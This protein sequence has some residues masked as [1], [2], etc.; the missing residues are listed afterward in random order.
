MKKTLVALVVAAVAGSANAG[1]ELYN[2]GGVTVNMKG[3]IEVQYVQAIG[4]DEQLTQKI[5]DAD[6]GFDT[7]YAID[8]TTQVGFYYEFSGADNDKKGQADLASTGD[9]YV[10]FYNDQIGT[11]KI[12]KLATQLDD[13]GIG[14]DH[15]FGITKFFDDAGFGGHEAVRYDLDKGQFYF[16]LGLIQNKL[17]ANSKLGEADGTHFDAKVG[18]RADAFDVRAFAGQSKTDATAPAVDNKFTLLALEGTYS[19]IENVNLQAAVYSVK[20]DNDNKTGNTYAL[21][22]DYTMNAW[23]FAGGFSSLD[24]DAGDYNTWFLNAGYAIAPSTTAYVEVGDTS[25]DGKDLGYG[26]GIKAVF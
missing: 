10:G 7:R 25:E 26:M 18:F 12:G 3:D 23:K 17:K 2:E 15:L 13:A 5:D 19:G 1:I 24:K 6:F 22:A 9:V 11:F 16:G 4:S 20:N 8:D 21:A 14:S